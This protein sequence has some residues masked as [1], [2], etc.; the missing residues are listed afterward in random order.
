M[1]TISMDRNSVARTG[2][3]AFSRILAAA[4]LCTAGL[5]VTGCSAPRT[6]P[7]VSGSPDISVDTPPLPDVVVSALNY[8]HDEIAKGKPMIYNLPTEM[9]VA[10]WNTFE[11][12]LA[13]AKPMCPGDTAVW[14]VRQV[15][16]DGS[17]AQVDIEYPS[18]DGFYQTVTVHMSGATGG[19]GYKPSFLQY[20]KVPVKDPVCQ[21]PLSVVEKQCGAAVAEKLR[22]EREAA[23]P[24]GATPPKGTAAAPGEEPS[25]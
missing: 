2:T 8:A 13:P 24:S 10:A 1:S 23:N 21:Q 22:K 12:R 19:F 17:K 16:I 5:A 20:W 7:S 18:R 9:N 25:K 3:R 6:W 15:R 14:T 4:L 11:R